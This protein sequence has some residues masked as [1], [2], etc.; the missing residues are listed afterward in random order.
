MLFPAHHCARSHGNRLNPFHLESRGVWKKLTCNNS[1]WDDIQPISL[2]ETIAN[3][4]EPTKEPIPEKKK[5]SPMMA[6]CMDLGAAELGPQS[7]HRG[8]RPA[9]IVRLITGGYGIPLD[10]SR[11]ADG[12]AK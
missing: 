12:G 6:L 4:P 3:K 9:Q 8:S 5:K 7:I 2:R 1:L 10:S 11:L